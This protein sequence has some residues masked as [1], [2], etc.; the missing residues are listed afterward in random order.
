MANVNAPFG[1]KPVRHQ[2]GGNIQSNAYPIASAYPTAIYTGDPVLMTTDGTI[3]I[4]IGTAGTP[5]T[6][7]LGVFGGVRY[8]D[9]AGVSF[10]RPY[11][12][13]GTVATN[14]EAIV[15]DDPQIIFQI[16]SDASGVAAG[17][18]GQLCDVEIVAG[19]PLTGVSRTNLDDSTG[20]ATTAKHLRI[21]RI[22]NN[23][24]NEAGAYAVV[25][26]MFA[27]HALS[28]TISGVGGI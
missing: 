25:E 11:C 7:I 10:L 19:N 20:T 1:L 3:I 4:A 24:V 28:G 15:Y 13:A 17:D 21:L 26:V 27:E 22:V 2:T 12:P 16:Q 23:G 5:S 14:I 8:T 9:A 6:T 18:V